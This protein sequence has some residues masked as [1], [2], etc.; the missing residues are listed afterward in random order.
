MNWFLF[1]PKYNSEVKSILMLRIHS[2]QVYILICTLTA[3][4]TSVILIKT[5]QLNKTEAETSSNRTC[6][7]TYLTKTFALEE[8]FKDE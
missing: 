3:V 8:I 5:S 2:K 7:Q 6:S 4:M 1:F